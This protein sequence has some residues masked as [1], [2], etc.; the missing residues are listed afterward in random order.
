MVIVS[1][2]QYALPV[3]VGIAPVVEDIAEL[4]TDPVCPMLNAVLDESGS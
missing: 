2:H 3:N 1:N 4:F